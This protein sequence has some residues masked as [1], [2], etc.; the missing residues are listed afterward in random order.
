MPASWREAH[1]VAFPG[2]AVW[3]RNPDL[4]SEQLQRE[5]YDCVDLRVAMRFPS[6]AVIQPQRHTNLQASSSM[7][8]Q[9]SR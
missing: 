9:D 8:P 3:R 7:K 1:A 6:L 5:A 4:H 2:K